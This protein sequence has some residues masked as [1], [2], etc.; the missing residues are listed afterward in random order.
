MNVYEVL[1][2]ALIVLLVVNAVYFLIR[3]RRR[4]KNGCSCEKSCS[5]CSGCS[6][7]NVTI[8]DDSKE[9]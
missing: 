9:E 7:P 5:N 1:I 3:S 6:S 4:G 2:I 8:E